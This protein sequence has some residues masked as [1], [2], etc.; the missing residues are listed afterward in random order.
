MQGGANLYQTV[1]NL[2]TVN[3]Q[4]K[5]STFHGLSSTPNVFYCC[6]KPGNV[7]PFK[8]HCVVY[9]G[10]GQLYIDLQSHHGA[11]KQPEHIDKHLKRGE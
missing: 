2:E 10:P 6:S 11:T 1:N 4:H 5:V 9:I 3:L 7:V 8:D